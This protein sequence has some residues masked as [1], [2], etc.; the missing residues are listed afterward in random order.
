MAAGKRHDSGCVVTNIPML[1]MKKKL[2]ELERAN[3]HQAILLLNPL[4]KILGR[5]DRCI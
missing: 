1:L 3:L 4:A 2:K 5:F